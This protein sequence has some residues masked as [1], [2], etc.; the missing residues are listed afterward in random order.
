MLWDYANERWAASRTV[1][2]QLWRCVGRFIDA[3]IFPGI[4]RIYH[5][6]DSIEREAAALACYDS[7]YPAA[8]DLLNEDLSLKTQ[9]ESGQLTWNTLAKKLTLQS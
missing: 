3:K 5:S 6:P 1:S 4:Q 2:P 8:K 9:I 7:D